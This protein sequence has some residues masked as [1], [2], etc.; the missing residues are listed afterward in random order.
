M[1]K[2]ASEVSEIRW[3]IINSLL[4]GSLVLL[5]N[6]TAGE[7]SFNGICLAIIAG[8]VV[9]ITKFKTYWEGSNKKGQSKLFS[10][11]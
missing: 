5:G 8:G 3:N 11:L 7:L 6:L 10:F 4:A 1:A 2:K 9:A